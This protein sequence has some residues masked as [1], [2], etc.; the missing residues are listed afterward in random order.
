MLLEQITIGNSIES[1]VYAYI[2]D[3]YFLPTSDFSPIFYEKVSPKIIGSDRKDL[4]WSRLQLILALSGKLLNYEK[5]NN[6]KITEQC[7]RL[8]SESGPHRY[9]FNLCNIFDP[10]FIQL[11]NEV[12]EYFPTNYLVYDDFEISSLGGKHKYL[13]PKVCEDLFARQIHY[14]TSSRVDGAN[15]VTDCV[16][17]SIMTKEQ[18]NSVDYSDSIVRFSVSV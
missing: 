1:L 5:V 6:I 9:S 18:I 10:T 8:S 12:C 13:E 2:N 3:T 4:T 16:V 14:Y 15:Y 7:L 11:D 17:E